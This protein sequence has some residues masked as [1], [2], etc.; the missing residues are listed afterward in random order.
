MNKLYNPFKMW[1]SW[2]GGGIGLILVF[3][4][5]QLKQM[6][7]WLYNF[8]IPLRILFNFFNLGGTMG[9]AIFT[10]VGWVIGNV[11][12]GFLI[13][14]VIHSLVRFLIRRKKDRVGSIGKK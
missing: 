14:W 7:D 3:L 13:G 11:F 8:F 10:F 2:V 9:G 6:P 5:F 4:A 1:G 12:L